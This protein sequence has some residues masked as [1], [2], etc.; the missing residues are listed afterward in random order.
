[1]II[2]TQ[3]HTNGA[4]R[5]PMIIITLNCTPRVHTEHL[6]SL[7]LNSTPRTPMIINTQQHTKGHLRSLTLNS[8]PRVH[9]EH[10]RSLTLNNTPRVHTEHLCDWI[11]EV[12]TSDFSHSKIHKI[13]ECHIVLIFS[14]LIDL[15]E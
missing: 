12:H 15:E 3:K 8:T 1:M 10:L 14:E 7:T 11:W 9:T 5:T 4:Y 2:N 6:R 13:W